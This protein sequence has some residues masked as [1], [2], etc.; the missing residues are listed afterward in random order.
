MIENVGYLDQT[1]NVVTDEDLEFKKASFAVAEETF[2]KLLQ[3]LSL[4]FR[5]VVAVC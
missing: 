5:K 2:S 3:L 4:K 1:K